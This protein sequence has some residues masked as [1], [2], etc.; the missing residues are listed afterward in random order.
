MFE[1]AVGIYTEGTL[2]LIKLSSSSGFVL[3]L[4]AMMKY[5]NINLSYSKIRS[6]F[7]NLSGVEMSQGGRKPLL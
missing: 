5:R 1:V 7:E 2:V 6:T 3:T 4:K